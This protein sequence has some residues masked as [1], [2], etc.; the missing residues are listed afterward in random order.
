[1]LFDVCYPYT[2]FD[3]NGINSSWDTWKLLFCRFWPWP[4]TYD[5]DL[6]FNTYLINNYYVILKIVSL[7]CNKSEIQAK[8]NLCIP[9]LTFHLWPW[10]WKLRVHN[11]KQFL[12][13]YALLYQISFKSVENCLRYDIWNLWTIYNPVTLAKGQ[14]H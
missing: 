4:L 6:S 1:M 5:L 2:K 9:Y 13:R 7:G 14:G 8:T 3:L 11:Q 12:D 10:P